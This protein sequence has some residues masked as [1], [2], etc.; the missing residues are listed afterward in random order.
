M[1]R[2]V[3]DRIRSGYWVLLSDEVEAIIHPTLHLIDSRQHIIS[4]ARL[5]VGILQ[6]T[7]RPYDPS[8]LSHDIMT[9]NDRDSFLPPQSLLENLDE[10]YKRQMSKTLM[11]PCRAK[12]MQ[13]VSSGCDAD[14]LKTTRM[15]TLEML[16]YLRTEDAWG[17]CLPYRAPVSF[18]ISAPIWNRRV[19][20]DIEA[21]S[22]SDEEEGVGNGFIVEVEDGDDDEE[23]EG[24]EDDDSSEAGKDGVLLEDEGEEGQESEVDLEALSQAPVVMSTQ[25]VTIS[26]GPNIDPNS[27]S[28]V[29]A[30]SFDIDRAQ[31]DEIDQLGQ[32]RKRKS[33]PLSIARAT[34]RR[35]SDDHL[36]TIETTNAN[37]IPKRN[38]SQESLTSSDTQPI[39]PPILQR[40]LELR[41]IQR[42]RAEKEPRV[43]KF[44]V[45][46]IP[47]PGVRLGR[48]TE[49]LMK[50]IYEV[51]L[52]P[53][54]RCRCTVCARSGQ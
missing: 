52:E 22:V 42:E 34:K 6:T 3:R 9:R 43:A 8:K 45:P 11:K 35:S 41:R 53:F 7:N 20:P 24:D 47:L 16:E 25:H 18:P 27:T 1:Y 13:H 5:P 23:E 26:T 28:S 15:S 39:T 44:E 40:E 38:I 14:Q 17:H 29:N 50:R 48:E 51:V 21:V 31:G 33:P 12:V 37:Q 46:H 54:V 10:M 2:W 36:P 4:Q 49:G 32:N 30:T 19:S